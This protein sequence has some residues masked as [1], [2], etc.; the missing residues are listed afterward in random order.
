[1]TNAI[2][3]DGLVVVQRRWKPEG[4][5]SGRTRYGWTLHTDDCFQ[6][7]GSKTWPAPAEEYPDTLRCRYCRPGD[8]HRFWHTENPDG[9]VTYACKGCD[10]TVTGSSVNTANAKMHRTHD[11]AMGMRLV[12]EATKDG[13]VIKVVIP[14]NAPGRQKLT[15]HLSTCP[16]IAKS[17]GASPAPAEL[18]PREVAPCIYCKPEGVPPIPFGAGGLDPAQHVKTRERAADGSVRIS[19]SCGRVTGYA[20]NDNAARSRWRRQHGL[21]I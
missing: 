20:P 9:T 16:Q 2:Y 15:L 12:A 3:A 11:Q 5:R 8:P 18:D 19:C 6:V 14:R 4:S 13:Q 7:R 21:Q 17:L 1:M 10:V